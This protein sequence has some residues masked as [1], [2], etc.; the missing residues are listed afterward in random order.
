M[1]RDARA[2]CSDREH[3]V[4]REPAE[5]VHRASA[6]RMRWGPREDVVEADDDKPPGSPERAIAKG[7]ADPACGAGR[8]S[9][10][11]RRTRPLAD[12]APQIGLHE[13]D[14]IEPE[15]RGGVASELQRRAREIGADHNAIGAREEQAHLPGAAA[16][17]EH[18]ASPGMRDRAGARSR[19]APPCVAGRKGSPSADIRETARACRSARPSSGAIAPAVGFDGQARGCRC[20]GVGAAHA[21]T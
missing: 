14:A 10:R 4:E 11:R 8:R 19:S 17:L 16:D 2:R 7:R 12:P 1:R 13:K 21:R 6:R 5:P 20:H 3:G 15:A 18:R 9:N